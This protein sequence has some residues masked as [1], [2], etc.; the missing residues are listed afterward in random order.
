[1]TPGL[2]LLRVAGDPA[3]P[4]LLDAARRL[5][6]WLADVPH[7]A[8]GLALYRPDIGTVRH[9]CWVDTI[10]HEPAFL[11]ALAGSTDQE[12]HREEALRVWRTHTRSAAARPGKPFLAHSC[13]AARGAACAATAGAAA[14]RGRCS[15]WWMRWSSCRPTCPAVRPRS[16]SSG[17]SPTPWS[18][19]QDASGFWR[20]LLDDR[21]AYLETSTAAMFGAA[22]TKAVPD[23]AA[24]RRLARAG[25][26][27]LA[28][29]PA[30]GSMT[31]ASSMACRRGRMRRSSVTTT[32]GHTATL[33][34]EVN[35]WGQG[36]GSPG[37]RRA[38][39]GQGW[40]A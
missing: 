25:R 13:E 15:G 6:D 8:T 5:A 11:A 27:R 2:G 32:S 30:R 18:A 37:D 29:R 22:F 21:E 20:T 7:T 9:S 10:Y 38:T 28:R 36:A 40:Q 17:V 31:R 34:T 33:P 19:V 35:W 1:M 23:R 16:V 12:R 24:G 4:D 39:C 14:T 26:S 3:D